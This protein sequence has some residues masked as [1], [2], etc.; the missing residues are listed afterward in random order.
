[1]AR[2][3][4]QILGQEQHRWLVRVFLVR[5][6]KIRRRRYLSRTVNGP[7]RQAQTY[8]NKMLRE[9]DLCR[10]VEGIAIAL[11]EYLNRWLKTAAK[12]KLRKAVSTP[13]LRPDA[14]SLRR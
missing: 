10:R 2:K 5:D 3:R 4:G 7:V 13:L 14:R 9:R 12:S 6:R 11:N 1:L 8:L